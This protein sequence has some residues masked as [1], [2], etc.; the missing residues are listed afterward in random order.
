MTT[1]KDSEGKRR[2][3]SSSHLVSERAGLT[4]PRQALRRRAGGAYVRVEHQ[5]GWRDQPV[6]VGWQRDGR[7]EIL[8][9]LA[10]GWIID[11]SGIAS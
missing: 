5:D 6:R 2:I 11:Q 4:I 7:V 1:P 9:G 10:E 8:E 3:V